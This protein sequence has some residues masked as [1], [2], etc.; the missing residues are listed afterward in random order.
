MKRL[1]ITFFTIL[2]YAANADTQPNGQGNWFIEGR[3][4]KSLSEASGW[5]D[6][7][8]VG[9]YR[10]S[11]ATG[12]GWE[13]LNSVGASIG[14]R[15]ANQKTSVLLTYEDFGTSDWK[16]DTFTDSNTLFPYT[17][18][19]T[20]F[21]VDISNIMLEVQQEY[22][23]SD[24]LNFVLVLGAGQS[25]LESDKYSLTLTRGDPSSARL[26]GKG[27]SKTNTSYRYGGGLVYSLS[28]KTQLIGVLQKSEYGKA[29]VWNENINNKIEFDTYAVEASMRLR[30]LF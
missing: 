27:I 16:A 6:N 2:T 10:Y 7:T 1:L 19:K 9:I 13:S 26:V 28:E 8:V 24:D 3:Y 12:E 18:G 25:S 15:F 30:Y 20:V 4:Q 22:V 11:A 14:R 21:P 17:Y 23:L 5:K 29:E